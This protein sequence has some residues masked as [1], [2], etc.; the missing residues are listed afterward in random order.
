MLG[1][2]WLP[3]AIMTTFKQVIDQYWPDLKYSVMKLQS[4]YSKDQIQSDIHFDNV[5]YK[6]LQFWNVDEIDEIRHY[7]KLGFIDYLPNFSYK[8]IDVVS[9]VFLEDPTDGY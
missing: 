8:R 5:F 3:D 2:E 6:N 1:Q 7:I 9:D 4:V